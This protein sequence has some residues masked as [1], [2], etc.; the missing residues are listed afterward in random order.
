MNE[1]KIAFIICTNNDLYFNECCYYINNLILP[2]GFERDII[3]IKDAPSMGAGYNAGMQSSDAKYKVYLHQDVFIQ[4][5]YFIEYILERF[6]NNHDIGMIGV[7]GGIGMPKTGVAYLA[8]NVGKVDCCDPDIAYRLYCTKAQ[9][10]DV[11]VDAVDGLLIA[12]QYDVPW[13]EDLFLNFDF[14]DVSQS[15]EM[16]RAGYHILV[17]Y[18]Q[19]P[20]VIHDGGFAKLNNYDKNRKMAL[21]EYPEFFTEENGFP[22]SYQE[23]WENLSEMLASEVR[24]SIDVGNWEEAVQLIEAYNKNPMKN[25]TLEQYSVM[26]EIYQKERSCGVK[27]CFFDEKEGY[28]AAYEKYM[29]VR[30]LLHRIEAGMDSSSYS[31]LKCAVIDGDISAEAML[32]I[33]LHGSCDKALVLQ[34]IISWYEVVGD[35]E[36]VQKLREVYNSIKGK[37]LLIAYSKRCSAEQ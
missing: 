13:R 16:R 34:K 7:M 14:Y 24:R 12:T 2:D 32:I 18:Q 1:K 11:I 9:K 27:Y 26:C 31:E 36:G 25:S 21:A 6:K 35:A 17:P 8:W 29:T 28:T 19:T 30:F 23:E 5:A 3:D 4:E 22:F 15:F 37:P 33:I 20:W 10:D